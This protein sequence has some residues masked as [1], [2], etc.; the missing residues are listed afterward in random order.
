MGED[1][2]AREAEGAGEAEEDEGVRGEK[3]SILYLTSSS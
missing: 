3:V 1:E 2:G